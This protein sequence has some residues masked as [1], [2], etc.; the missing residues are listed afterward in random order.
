MKLR[1]RNVWHLRRLRM[2]K[3]KRERPVKR[4]RDANSMRRYSSANG[5]PSFPRSRYLLP[6]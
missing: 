6:S 1:R 5:M 3:E 4:R 2:P